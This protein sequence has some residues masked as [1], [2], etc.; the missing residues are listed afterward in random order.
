MV[1]MKLRVYQAKMVSALSG[2]QHVH[3]F[4]SL[5]G[6][7]EYASIWQGN[8]RGIRVY[9]KSAAVELPQFLRR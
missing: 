3:I 6:A 7:L 5:R 1:K 2:A 9:I 8:L 4:D